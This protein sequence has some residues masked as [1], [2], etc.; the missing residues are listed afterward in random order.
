MQFLAGYLGVLFLVAVCGLWRVPRV[1]AMRTRLRW[2][3]GF[4][5]PGKIALAADCGC[6]LAGSRQSR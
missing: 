6:G 3:A 2:L 5:N 1:Q 4:L